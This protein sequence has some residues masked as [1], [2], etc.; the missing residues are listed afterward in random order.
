[1]EFISSENPRDLEF[2]FDEIYQ[3]INQEMDRSSTGDYAII[4]HMMD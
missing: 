3:L 2:V 1:M 4:S